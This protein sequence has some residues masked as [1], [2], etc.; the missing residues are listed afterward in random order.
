MI[1][2]VDSELTLYL[3]DL[4][5][6]RSEVQKSKEALSYRSAAVVELN[7]IQDCKYFDH[8]L[9]KQEDHHNFLYDADEIKREQLGHLKQQLS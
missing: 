4:E 6:V 1:M 5:K 8:A 2:V 3:F 7:L 9:L